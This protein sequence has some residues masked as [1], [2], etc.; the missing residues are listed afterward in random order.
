[1]KQTGKKLESERLAQIFEGAA[2]LFSEK[3]YHKTTIKDIGQKIGLS[4]GNIYY[5]V[6]TK[7][8]ILYLIHNRL[9]EINDEAHINIMRRPYSPMEKLVEMIK[10]EF[11]TMRKYEP[12]VMLIYQENHVLGSNFKKTLLRRER[13]HI[14]FFEDVIKEG[15]SKGFFRRCNVRMISNQI[16]I[17]LDGYIL[18]RWDLRNNVTAGEYLENTINMILGNLL[19]ERQK[20]I[21]VAE[22]PLAGPDRMAVVTQATST[23]GREVLRGLAAEGFI[24]VAQDDDGVNLRKLCDE[25]S[26]MWPEIIPFSGGPSKEKLSIDL[27]RSINQQFKGID[28]YIHLLESYHT[29]HSKEAISAGPFS[30]ANRLGKIYPILRQVA[31]GM[32][33]RGG[34]IIILVV[35]IS[36][37]V[38]GNAYL[39]RTIERITA[40]FIEG[41]AHELSPNGI[42]VN[43]I[44]TRD[45]EKRVR[46]SP[47]SINTGAGKLFKLGNM[48]NLED[49]AKVIRFISSNKM[50]CLTGQLINIS[51]Y[52]V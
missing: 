20:P 25:L 33:P 18:K 30:L 21:S 23:L 37:Q 4:A 38:N 16:K 32:K 5:Y 3:G 52:S 24:L 47:V 6:K 26:S 12:L 17:L 15:I 22:E 44:L 39:I 2:A 9:G 41:L 11:A 35:E 10:S 45:L 13:R 29:D 40:T 43:G 1:M 19:A 36:H 49:A 48:S 14:S 31:A 28:V 8:E 27:I 46:E 7:E 42:M 34:G 50:S 51:A